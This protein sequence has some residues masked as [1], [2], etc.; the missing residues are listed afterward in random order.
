MVANRDVPTSLLPLGAASVGEACL[1]DMIATLQGATLSVNEL[2]VTVRC[3]A[4][5][6][7]E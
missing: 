4:R 2:I 5:L 3:D 6:V 1:N 7:A